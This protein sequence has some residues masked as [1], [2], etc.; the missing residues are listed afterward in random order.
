MLYW[1]RVQDSQKTAEGLSNYIGIAFSALKDPLSRAE[2]ILKSHGIEIA[3]EDQ[4]E[5]F[6]LIS[7]IMDVREQ[8]EDATSTKVGKIADVNY[9]K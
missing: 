4:L 9:G 8:L 2:Y 7:E 5:D 6:E 1:R 3:E